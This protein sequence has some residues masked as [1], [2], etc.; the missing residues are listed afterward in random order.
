ML[1][2]DIQT[3]EI[4]TQYDAIKY[5]GNRVAK[6][7]TEEYRIKRAEDVIDRY[8]LPHMHIF[9]TQESRAEAKSLMRVQEHILS[10]RFGGPIIG[11][12]HDHISGAYLLTRLGSN[13]SEEDVFQMVKKARMELPKPRGRDWT[14][15]EIFSLLLPKDLNMGDIPGVRW[16]VS[17][18]NNVALEEMVKGKIEKPVR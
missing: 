16:K 6:G 2:D 15:K 1:I 8:L 17:K 18:V 7:M 12:I 14:G 3:S 13:F 9:Q 4:S 5:I 10:P 11:G